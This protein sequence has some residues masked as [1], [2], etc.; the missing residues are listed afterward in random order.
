MN[1]IEYIK[2]TKQYNEKTFRI[3]N[4]EFFIETLNNAFFKNGFVILEIRNITDDLYLFKYTSFKLF[5]VEIDKIVD[6][7][8]IKTIVSNLD[9]KKDEN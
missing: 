3:P 5:E 8:L 7:N 1:W 4:F 6:K 9:I 2:R